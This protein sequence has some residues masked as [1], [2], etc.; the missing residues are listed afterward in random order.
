M[1]EFHVVLPTTAAGAPHR[2]DVR[3]RRNSEESEIRVNAFA[4]PHFS[5]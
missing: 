1:N 3:R 4:K 2:R 5:T